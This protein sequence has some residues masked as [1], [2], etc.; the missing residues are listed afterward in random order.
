MGTA[1]PCVR[2][3][4]SAVRLIQSTIADDVT[5]LLAPLAAPLVL[6]RGWEL[7]RLVDRLVLKASVFFNGVNSI[8]RL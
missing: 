6:L 7:G 2:R 8:S 4:Y 1:C 3:Y 5:V